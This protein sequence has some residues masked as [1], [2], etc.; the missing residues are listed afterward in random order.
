[1]PNL[2]NW[3]NAWVKVSKQSQATPSSA[4]TSGQSSRPLHGKAHPNKSV[5]SPQ[6][7]NTTTNFHTSSSARS[8]GV[9]GMGS[10]DSTSPHSSLKSLSAITDHIRNATLQQGRSVDPTVATFTQPLTSSGD[11]EQVAIRK[12]HSRKHRRRLHKT[13]S[14]SDLIREQA[15]RTG[16]RRTSHLKPEESRRRH[17]QHHSNSPGRN[18]Q[19]R[20]PPRNVPPPPTLHHY[21]EPETSFDAQPETSFDAQSSDGSS[22]KSIGPSET[23]TTE[24]RSNTRLCSSSAGDRHSAQHQQ[25]NFSAQS[26]LALFGVAEFFG[27]EIEELPSV[28]TA[29]TA[30]ASRH[31]THAAQHGLEDEQP[32][33]LQPYLQP[34]SS[35]PSSYGISN[36][37]NSSSTSTSTRLQ[38]SHHYESNT[39]NATHQSN[40]IYPP[41]PASR[42]SNVARHEANASA[43]KPSTQHAPAP[44]RA[45]AAAPPPPDP[46]L[47]LG[48]VRLPFFSRPAPTPPE[49][50]EEDSKD[51]ADIYPFG[52]GEPNCEGCH[53]AR[54]ELQNTQDS[55]EYMRTLAIRKEYTCAQCGKANNHEALGKTDRTPTVKKASQQMSEVT[56]RHQKQVVQLIKQRDHWQRNMHQKLDKVSN[57]SRSLNNESSLRVAEARG[58]RQELEEVKTERDLMAGE[59][60]ELKAAM[61]VYEKEREEHR[62]VQQKMTVYETEGLRQ[63]EQ[64][65]VMRDSMIAQLSTQLAITL[66][67]LSLEREQQKQR[68]Q[69][70]FPPTTGRNG[71]SQVGNGETTTSANDSNENDHG[72]VFAGNSES[73]ELKRLREQ[74]LESQ[75]KLESAQLQAN[76]RETALLFKCE[77]LKNQLENAREPEGRLRPEKLTT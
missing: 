75:R 62:L 71:Q 43:R 64:A 35:T 23:V 49:N 66:D 21:V 41:L 15:K 53:V 11:P 5:S 19:H 17:S 25:N 40:D 52:V 18:R 50:S 59:L 67:T 30:F 47:V 60:E 3:L 68:R 24:R 44:K 1:M 51:N 32:S 70:I 57:L 39:R 72:Y 34:S 33:Y 12:H 76:Q 2:Q 27:T 38:H 28:T 46:G 4:N 37:T 7:T 10:K 9:S 8:H 13:N 20:Q 45:A 69:I 55:L 77:A 48:G 31:R 42:R 74:L 29:S 16:G 56:S 73:E 63:A 58:L 26:N 65:I 61:Q 14:F 36:D 54:T 6:S 22:V